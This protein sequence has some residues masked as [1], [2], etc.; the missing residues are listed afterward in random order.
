MTEKT[1]IVFHYTVG[2]KLRDIAK[3][4]HLKT[5]P[6]QPKLG[7]KPVVW[8]SSEPFYEATANKM[9]MLPGETRSRLSTM[10]EMDSRMG[11]M[12][13]FRFDPKDFPPGFFM[14]WMVLKNRAKM[15][16]KIV[17]RL[18]KRAKGVNARPSRWYGTLT[19]LPITQATLERL[20][21]KTSTWMPQS[22]EEA[23]SFTM[24]H[25]SVKQI[26]DSEIPPSLRAYDEE[27]S[28]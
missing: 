22:I 7:E 23:M 14:P 21:L 16:K 3:D 2:V 9:V 10:E 26:L 15:P 8:L 17:T 12:Y 6:T 27:W 4:G 28:S 11:G 13:R 18:V 25:D 19:A 5:T 1:P 24:P 20:D